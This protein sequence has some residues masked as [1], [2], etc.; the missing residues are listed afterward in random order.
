M[1]KK[2]IT[3][4]F[5]IFFG[6]GNLSAAITVVGSSDAHI[7][8]KN[9]KYGYTTQSSIFTC[10]KAISEKTISKKDLDATRI[11]L[12]IIYN[13]KSKPRMALEQFEIAFK[14]ESMR[15]EVLLNQGNSLLLLKDYNGALEKYQA[16]YEN[17]LEDIS[18]IYFNKGMAHEYLGNIDE[19]VSFYKKAVTLNP[20]LIDYFEN[21]RRKLKEA[22][23]WNASN[24]REKS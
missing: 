24:E 8:Y 9:A 15:A 17:N 20:S 14:N 4:S 22:G 16:S 23:L 5:L 11:N 1:F 12:G 13:N 18:A 7:C 6:S 19:A 10:L 3:F 21:K 2:F